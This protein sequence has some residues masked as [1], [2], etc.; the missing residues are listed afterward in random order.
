MW[1][2][3]ALICHTQQGVDNSAEG[4]KNMNEYTVFFL[5]STKYDFIAV[6]GRYACVCIYITLCVAVLTLGC[7]NGSDSDIVITMS[8]VSSDTQLC[9]ELIGLH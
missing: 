2:V 6:T 1:R 8:Q 4:K 7:G 3:N 5:P 9:L